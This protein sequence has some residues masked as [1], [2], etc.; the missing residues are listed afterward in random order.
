MKTNP[1]Y[2]SYLQSTF[3]I[4]ESEAISWWKS[5]H[6]PIG[7]SIRINTQK[8]SIEKFIVE[9]EKVGWHFTPTDIPEVFYV[10]R[11][12]TSTALGATEEHQ[13]GQFY[14]QEA[15]A[16][17][18]PHIMR[19]VLK[20]SSSDQHP[21]LILDMCSSPWGKTT[22]LA[23]YFPDSLI[24]ANEAD[25]GR[26]PQLYENIDRMWHNNI[27]VTNY[28]W[29][30]YKHFPHLFDAILLD[31][32]CSWEWC[33]FKTKEALKNWHIKNIR[34]IAKLQ[35]QLFVTAFRALKPGWV[36]LYST[37]TLNKEENEGVIEKW[38]KKIQ[39]ES[40]KYKVWSIQDEEE[41]KQ[42]NIETLKHWNDLGTSKL[43]LLDSK[44][45]WPHKTGTGWFF[46]AAF[47]K[48]S[49]DTDDT[50]GETI[51]AHNNILPG[52]R[53]IDGNFLYQFKKDTYQCSH[54]LSGLME[55]MYF[56][57]IGLPIKKS[58][59]PQW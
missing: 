5:M 37:C 4:S 28:D 16:S 53:D 9:H 42:C 13:S 25:K 40:V 52:G 47:Q 6:Q 36:L 26:L 15:A 3:G 56:T 2:I 50:F 48:E 43:T 24:I 57:K 21:S 19:K 45:L 12:D 44:R 18:P 23:E 41:I 31:A 1:R 38:L 49:W 46:Y 34:R 51:P 39:K 29:R 54:D 35:Y 7:K 30:Y 32:P 8:V 27:C 59:S 17:H 55:T 33:A 11:D 20:N 58:D 22:Q 10:D 14:I